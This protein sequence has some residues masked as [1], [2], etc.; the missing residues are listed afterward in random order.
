MPYVASATPPVHVLLNPFAW[1]FWGLDFALW[2]LIPPLVGPIKMIA[3]LFRGK[4]SKE[5]KTGQRINARYE[6]IISRAGGEYE[7]I[8]T[9]HELMQ[10]TFAKYA[11]KNCFGTRTYLGEHTPEGA[12][13]PLKMFGE[14]T[15]KSYREV[16]HRAAAFG[17]GLVALGCKPQ[18][19]NVDYEDL[20]GPYT[21]LLWE[22][23]C[24]DWFTA[25][26]GAGGQSIAV[27]TSYATLGIDAVAEALNNSQCP[28]IVCNFS[29]IAECAA[30]KSKC[31]DLTTVIYTHHFTSEAD[32]KKGPPKCP[33]LKVISFDDVCKL[34]KETAFTAPTPSTIS[35][36]MYTSGS[37]GK[38]KGVKIKHESFVASVAGMRDWMLSTGS[39]KEGEETYLGYLPAAHILEL[40]AEHAMIAMGSEIGFADTKT[41][42]SK[43]ACRKRP[44]GTINT[45]PTY[46]Y[47]PGG[48]QEFRPTVLAGVPK[49]WDIF[50]KVKHTSQ[51]PA[52]PPPSSH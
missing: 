41:I 1:V 32:I 42:S 20:T 30:L 14:T 2:L 49:V 7:L 34:K 52:L 51:P 24:A 15:W 4:Y 31:K 27:A 47:P 16:Q 46:P 26:V 6:D 36:I 45:D 21:I 48:I 11:S 23:T 18:P 35:V 10:H 13:F 39:L 33:G 50:K 22:D 37:T 44:D 8:T 5:E 28:V 25:L 19:A 40:V 3:S 17:A 38:P 43:G 9:V 12:R 29:K